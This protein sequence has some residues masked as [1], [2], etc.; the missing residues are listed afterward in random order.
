MT[1]LRVRQCD[2]ILKREIVETQ[3]RSDLGNDKRDG[4]DIGAR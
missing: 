3:K 4:D 2:G 1:T